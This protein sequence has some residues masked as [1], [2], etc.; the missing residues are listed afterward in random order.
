MRVGE[1]RSRASTQVVLVADDDPG[2]VTIISRVLQLNGFLPITACDGDEA[3]RLFKELEP[4]LVILDVRMPRADGI[5]VCERI[6]AAADTPVIM[7]TAL[8]DESDAT[9]G[10]EA[11]AD[12]YIRKPFGA[13]EL[14]ARI[15][16]VLRR[17]R[18]K[19]A[20]VDKIEA[21][22][23]VI[24]ETEHS[25][26]VRGDELLLSKTEFALLAFLVRNRNRVLTHDQVLERVWGPEYVGSHH[27]LRVAMSRLRQKLEAAGVDMIETLQGVGYRLRAA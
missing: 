20:S 22:P 4:D 9:R 27:V 10:L 3:W 21:G 16:A 19:V 25:A 8:E 5:A 6:R 18:P 11:G 15:R 13:A 24:D 17:A 2:I 1:G 14:V 26:L 7:V 23:L 12:D